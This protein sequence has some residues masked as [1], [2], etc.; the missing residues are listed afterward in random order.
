MNFDLALIRPLNT[1]VL[2]SNKTKSKIMPQIQK[3][4]KNP[5]KKLNAL[6]L[7]LKLNI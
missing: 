3:N 2:F 1:D 5:L 4:N 6:I 7:L